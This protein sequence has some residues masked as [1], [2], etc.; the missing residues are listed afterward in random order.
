MDLLL[1][2]PDLTI[3][4]CDKC[5]GYGYFDY[6]D[7]D[8]PTPIGCLACNGTGEMEVCA[9]CGSVPQ[10]VNGRETCHCAVS[11]DWEWAA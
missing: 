4:E 7:D 11:V 2:L 3:T 1:N 6:G 9:G 5:D 10:V 8:D